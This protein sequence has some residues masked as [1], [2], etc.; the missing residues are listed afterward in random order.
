MPNNIPIRN[1]SLFSIVKLFVYYYV[2]KIVFC[3]EE[4]DLDD[5]QVKRRRS[6]A[7]R[8]SEGK[9][10]AKYGKLPDGQKF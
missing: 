3:N 10:T 5:G 4:A 1:S 2:N 6:R 7:L 9:I 8:T